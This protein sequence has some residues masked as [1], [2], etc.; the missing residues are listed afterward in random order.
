MRIV[1]Q[2]SSSL[3]K[4]TQYNLYPHVF[5]DFFGLTHRAK[6]KKIFSS[7]CCEFVVYPL[8]FIM[9]IVLSIYLSTVLTFYWRLS[10]SLLMQA[11]NCTII[12]YR[13][14]TVRS[15][16]GLL[17]F[18]TS[19]RYNVRANITYYAPKF[20]RDSAEEK[21]RN[22]TWPQ[23]VTSNGTIVEGA[24]VL[25]ETSICTQSTIEQRTECI[26]REVPELLQIF[27]TP[28]QYLPVPINVSCLYEYNNN[29]SS[30]LAIDYNR[31]IDEWSQQTKFTNISFPTYT[32]CFFL[33]LLVGKLFYEELNVLAYHYSNGNKIGIYVPLRL[34]HLC[35]CTRSKII[36]CDYYIGTALVKRLKSIFIPCGSDVIEQESDF[37]FRKYQ[38]KLEEAEDGVLDNSID[39]AAATALLMQQA[40]AANNQANANDTT[41]LNAGNGAVQFSGLYTSEMKALMAST[42]KDETEVIYWTFRPSLKASLILKSCM[43]LS[44][45]LSFILYAIISTVVSVIAIFVANSSELLWI[46]YLIFSIVYVLMTIEAWYLRGLS[47]IYT[48]R[49]YLTSH[50]AV[51][52]SSN[53]LREHEIQYIWFDDILRVNSMSYHLPTLLPTVGD[54][55]IECKIK[56]KSLLERLIGDESY[57]VIFFEQTRHADTVHEMFETLIEAYKDRVEKMRL[58][59]KLS[60]FVLPSYA[61]PTSASG[62][63]VVPTRTAALA[64]ADIV[65]ET[66]DHDETSNAVTLWV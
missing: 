66:F 41:A 50:R 48:R 12:S 37:N 6:F 58:G 55:V 44:P 61:T 43:I 32:L 38:Y 23:D 57:N 49:Y 63:S 28:Y 2:L 19:V 47:Y 53:Y 9:S 64:I 51:I 60:L 42:A 26:A 8:L 45:L 52:Y 40:A 20:Q 46:D 10:P 56:Y 13:N 62:G 34:Q 22:T 36:R 1:R 31:L 54:V 30:A 33:F 3:R 65:I 7:T 17:F 39:A 29:S 16:S 4:H 11:Q 25:T 14:E 59:R 18:M 5:Y 24:W 27:N 21:Q 15:N 35:N